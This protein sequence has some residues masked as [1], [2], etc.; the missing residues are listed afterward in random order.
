MAV[1]LVSQMFGKGMHVPQRRGEGLQVS[2]K[3]MMMPY[4]LPPLIGNWPQNAVGMGA[5]KEKSRG[6][7]L[8]TSTLGIPQNTGFNRNV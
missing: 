5:R 1:D 4:Y 2:Q 7:V 6:I 8:L 3:P